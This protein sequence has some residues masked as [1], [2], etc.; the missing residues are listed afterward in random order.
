[1]TIHWITNTYCFLV[2]NTLYPVVPGWKPDERNKKA[3]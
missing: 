2:K 3:F 1:M